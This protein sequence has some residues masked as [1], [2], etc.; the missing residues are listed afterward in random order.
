MHGATAAA[1]PE[2]VG[3]QGRR[4]LIKGRTILSMDERVGNPQLL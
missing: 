3:V 4:T 2:G 1:M